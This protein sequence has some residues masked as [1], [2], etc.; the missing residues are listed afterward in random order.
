[1]DEM[2]EIWGA[3]GWGPGP[4]EGGAATTVTP[5]EALRSMITATASGTTSAGQQLQLQP[6]LSDP[7]AHTLP[8]QL[9]CSGDDGPGKAGSG[10]GAVEVMTCCDAPPASPALPIDSG[11][12]VGGVQPGSSR[13]ALPSSAAPATSACALMQQQQQLVAMMGGLGGSGFPV[14]ACLAGRLE[15]EQAEPEDYRLDGSDDDY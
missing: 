9:Q 12:G 11:R 10:H 13:Q 5:F 14:P 6:L 15:G 7:E 8:G 1:M 3:A 2:E 4:G